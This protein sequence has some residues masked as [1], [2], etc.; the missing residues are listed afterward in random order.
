MLNSLKKNGFTKQSG[1]VWKHSEGATLTICPKAFVLCQNH[2]VTAARS[3][4]TIIIAREFPHSVEDIS[5]APKIWKLK[6]F[7]NFVK[8]Q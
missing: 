7:R 1:N 3:L 4:S 6:P 8:Q 5:A 2:V